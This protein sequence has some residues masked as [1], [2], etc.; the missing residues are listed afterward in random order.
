M[1]GLAVANGAHQTLPPKTM[2]RI[3]KKSHKTGPSVVAN[4]MKIAFKKTYTVHNINA[5]TL[6]F[7]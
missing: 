7:K 6:S 1:T 2:A 4:Y 5:L 3:S